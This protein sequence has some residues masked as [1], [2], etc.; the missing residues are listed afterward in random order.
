MT[1][2]LIVHLTQAIFLSICV[3]YTKENNYFASAQKID[4][5]AKFLLLLFSSSYFAHYVL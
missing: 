2:C 5:L 3:T 1:I 4:K